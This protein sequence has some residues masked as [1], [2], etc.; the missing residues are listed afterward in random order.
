MAKRDR[1]WTEEKIA[2]FVKQGRGSGEGIHYKPWLT[3]QDVPS[4]GRV[5]RIRGNK[6]GR[7]HQLMSDLERDFFYLMEWADE[8]I[9]IR[10]QFPLDRELT[11]RIAEEKNIRHPEDVVSKTPLVMTTDFLITYRKGKEVFYIAPTIKPADKLS[12]Q[13]IIE[14]LEIEREYWKIKNVQWGI[15]TEREVPQKSTCKNIEL[16]HNHYDVE[17]SIMKLADL[18]LMFLSI[19]Q[20]SAI[21]DMLRKFE[22]EYNLDPGIGLSSLKHL[23]ATKKVLMDMDQLFDVSK[24]NAQDLAVNNVDHRRRWAT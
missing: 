4:E 22:I 8:V 1:G 15:V 9:D 18:L 20:D 17:D 6:T 14:K 7:I 24:M 5:H 10:E 23:L 21:R 11:L 13:R 16:F 19:Y 2:R 3:I 12:D